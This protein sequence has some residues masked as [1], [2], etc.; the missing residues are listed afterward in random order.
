MGDLKN[1]IGSKGTGIKANDLIEER[2]KVFEI[3]LA[4]DPC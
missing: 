2:V 4:W 1:T 3:I